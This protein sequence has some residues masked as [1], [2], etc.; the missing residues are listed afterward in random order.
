MTEPLPEAARPFVTF[1]IVLRAHG[2]AVAPEQTTGFIEA[3]GL[4]GPRNMDDIYQASRAMLGTT[5]R[6]AARIRR[7]V[8]RAFPRPGAGGA[9]LQR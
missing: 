4:L 8:P 1:P 7:A 5:A 9:R 2:F 6:S 3:V